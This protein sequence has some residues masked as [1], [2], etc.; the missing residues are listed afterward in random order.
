MLE[1]YKDQQV[2]SYLIPIFAIPIISVASPV[3]IV[4]SYLVSQSIF[5]ISLPYFQSSSNIILAD[6][7]NLIIA[8][9]LC[10]LIVYLQYRSRI[11][12]FNDT[13]G[14]IAGDITEKFIANADKA[15]YKAKNSG[16][17]CVMAYE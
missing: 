8:I 17:N 13:Y 6:D 12:N 9:I 10:C 1:Q 4:C 2:L 14:H 16:R 3:V 15:L 7:F 5:M 11:L